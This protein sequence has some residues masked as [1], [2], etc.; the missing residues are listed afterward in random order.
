MMKR[1]TSSS[2]IGAHPT[3]EVSVIINLVLSFTLQSLALYIWLTRFFLLFVLF[4][5]EFFLEFKELTKYC[6]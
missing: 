6:P 2:A 3:N 4:F 5:Q 1:H